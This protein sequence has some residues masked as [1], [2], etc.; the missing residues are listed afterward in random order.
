MTFRKACSYDIPAIAQIYSDIH[1]Q[2]ERGLAVIG[3]ARDVYPTEKT[4]EAALARND[5]F[6]ME[7]CGRIVGT[8]IINQ[9]QVD[10]YEGAPWH[11]PASP[12]EV[13]VL[14]TL[15]ISPGESGKGYGSAFVRFY[16]NYART[17]HCP[18]LRMDT[19]ARNAAARALY[20]KLGYEEIGIVP[21]VFNGIDGV[22]LV[23]LEKK[24]DL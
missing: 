6:V 4:A 23:L 7:T 13:M 3:W 20:H 24:L 22:Q 18:Y 14:H 21:C 15:V 2:E 16:E 12:D 9:N 5:L 17:H 10:V 8:A 1:T 19:N 11:F